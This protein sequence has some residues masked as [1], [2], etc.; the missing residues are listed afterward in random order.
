MK[1]HNRDLVEKAY[2]EG[3]KSKDAFAMHLPVVDE[4]TS[5]RAPTLLSA[6]SAAPETSP[7]VMSKACPEIARRVGSWVVS[8]AM[9][10]D[11]VIEQ[12]KLQGFTGSVCESCGSTKMKRNGSC[13]V[14]IDCGLT[15]G[16]S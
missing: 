7:S 6:T 16:C 4:G 13:E 12:A 5:V 10:R 11:V 8:T 9:M 14:C 3:S 2:S 15:S 1:F